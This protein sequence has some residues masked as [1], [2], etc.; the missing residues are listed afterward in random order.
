MPHPEDIKIGSRWKYPG[1]ETTFVV[2]CI[3]NLQM[4]PMARVVYK[5][6]AS[7]MYYTVPIQGWPYDFVE[8]EK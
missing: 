7:G 4:G 6:E 3:A 1:N 8:V 2:W 5:A